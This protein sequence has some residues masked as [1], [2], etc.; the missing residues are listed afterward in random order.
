MDKQRRLELHTDAGGDYDEENAVCYLSILLAE[1][2]PGYSS[3]IMMKDMDQWGYTFRLG[4]AHDWFE[5][6]AEDA[7]KWLLSSG[8]IDERSRVTGKMRG[9]AEK[10]H[11]KISTT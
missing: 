10:H 1:A 2:L 11:G 9:L 4:S 6:D 8:I 7:R 3:R 5:Q